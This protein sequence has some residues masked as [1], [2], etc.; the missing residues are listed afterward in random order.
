MDRRGSATPALPRHV[1]ADVLDVEPEPKRM[2]TDADLDEIAAAFGD[3]ADLKAPVL[4]RPFAEGGRG[5]GSQN[6]TSRARRGTRLFCGA[7]GFFTT[8][9]E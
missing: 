4:P 1:L 3:L 7:P 6:G 2:C 9:A 8:S 5:C